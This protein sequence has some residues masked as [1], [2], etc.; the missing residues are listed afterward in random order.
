MAFSGEEMCSTCN[1]G[2]GSATPASRMC[3]CRASRASPRANKQPSEPKLEPWT[4]VV[5]STR[6]QQRKKVKVHCKKVG[7]LLAFHLW[8]PRK[9]GEVINLY[10]ALSHERRACLKWL[11]ESATKFDAYFSV[12]EELGDKALNLV[13]LS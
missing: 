4:L 6:V 7:F 10:K 11:S 13:G 1:G 12:A 8:S 9:N 3:H 2:G 5:S